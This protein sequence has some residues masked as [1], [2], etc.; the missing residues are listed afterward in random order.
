M[1]LENGPQRFATDTH[2]CAIAADALSILRLLATYAECILSSLMD[3]TGHAKQPC[4][5]P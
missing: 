5:V 2:H 3:L 1:Q 4:S